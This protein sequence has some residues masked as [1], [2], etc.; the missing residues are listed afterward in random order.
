MIDPVQ[1]NFGVSFWVSVATICLF[2]AVI[3][4]E[5][6]QVRRVIKQALILELLE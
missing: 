6:F 1:L 5:Q 3:I 4:Y 2:I